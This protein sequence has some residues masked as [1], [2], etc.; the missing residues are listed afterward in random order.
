MNFRLNYGQTI[1]R[2]SFR[3]LAAYYSYDP[4]VSDFVEGNPL[5][6]LTSIDNYD[7]RWEW[8]PHPG[9]LLSVSLFYKNL[10]NAIERGNVKQ[11]GDVITFFNNDA[12]LY[13]V[14][15]E[16]R[17]NLDFLGTPFSA[18][19]LGGN[20]SLV[21]SEVKLKPSDLSNKR[22][23]FPN[24]SP[25]RPLYDQSPYV[26]N[27]DLNY[28]NPWA[29]TTAALIFNMAGPRVAI[30]KINTDDVY[31]QATPGL[32]FVLSQK[33][34]RNLT[35]KFG[36]KNLLDPKIER[37][38]GKDSTLLYSSYRRGRAVGLSFSYNF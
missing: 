31:D 10:K 5:L 4:I 25:T 7:M 34:G 18:F 9:E 3:E 17:K 23:F 13:G 32:D 26:L 1:A 21:E 28:S 36:A 29:G 15:F 12:K 2:P 19:S 20:L 27:F 35:L 8:F 6:K 37:T 38:Y 14:E 33:I 22:K 30:T 24:I 16:V 11:E